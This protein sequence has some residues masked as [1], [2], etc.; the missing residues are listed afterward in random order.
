VIIL[1][2]APLSLSTLA[3]LL[4]VPEGDI[5]NR[6]DPFYSVLTIS[7]NLNLPIQILHLSFHDY[8]VDERTKAQKSTAQ[9][10]VDKKE[11]HELIARQC[12]IIMGRCLRKNICELSSYGT[13]RIEIDPASIARFLPP[14]LQ[15]ACRY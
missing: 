10:W 5:S 7:S 1:L 8:L 2:A 9:F 4:E 3:E 14:A 11:K 13:S 15:Y 12:L 6:L